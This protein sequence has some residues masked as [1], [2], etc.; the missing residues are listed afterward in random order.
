MTAKFTRLK[1]FQAKSLSKFT[2]IPPKF[3][4][5]TI[6]FNTLPRLQAKNYQISRKL[7]NFD[8]FT[9]KKQPNY[10]K[11]HQNSIISVILKSINCQTIPKL[12]KIQYSRSFSEKTIKLYQNPSKFNT[13]GHL[14]AKKSP[15]STKIHFELNILDHFA[16]KKL[17]NLI[18]IHSKTPNRPT[19]DKKK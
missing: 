14:Q 2:Q 7:K 17:P 5:I 19:R 1:D 9:S 12:I 3:S 4:H 18:K 8:H 6:T 13:P 10:T 16:S 15:K 11:I